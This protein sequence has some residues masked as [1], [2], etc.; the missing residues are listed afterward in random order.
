[1]AAYFTRADL[2]DRMSADVVLRVFD[3]N[4]DGN[5]DSSSIARFIA[6]CSSE[7]DSFVRPIYPTYPLTAPIPNQIKNLALD[8]A[9][10]RMA[11]RQPEVVRKDWI[12]LRKIVH[13]DLT[14]LRSGKTRLDVPDGQSPNPP[15]NVGATVSSGNSGVRTA[16]CPGSFWKDMGDF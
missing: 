1:M 9:E 13:E 5:S 14:N 6:D 8:V 11:R 15:S 2:E 4:N 16:N 12:E 10:W 7:V 3:D